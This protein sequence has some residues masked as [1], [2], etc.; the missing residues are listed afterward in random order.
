MNKLLVLAG[1]TA[2]G[3]SD[4][5]LGLAERYQGEII[6][7]DS[8]Q[9]YSGL[10]FITFPPSEDERKKIPHYLI[11][12]IS[13]KEEF[14]VANYLELAVPIVEEIWE[15]GRLPIVVGGTGLYIKVLLEGIFQLPI[16]SDESL[17]K[18]LFEVF[19]DGSL[20]QE[21]SQVD[22]ESANKIHPKDA[23]R[24][25]RAMEVYFLTGKPL[26][27]WKK[28]R[29]G[30]I[31]QRAEKLCFVVLF[32]EREELKKRIWNRLM[33]LGE[34]EVEKAYGLWQKG[35]SRTAAKVLGLKELV[36]VAQGKISLGDAK[37]EIAKATYQYARRQMI[38]FRKHA[39]EISQWPNASVVWLDCR[40]R[41]GF[42]NNFVL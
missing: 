42:L 24:I 1:Q 21:L 36:A 2:T 22:P 40:D 12:V 32:C 25:I 5:A 38:W 39:R 4:L 26:S 18:K 14:N 17:R 15:R 6:S 7:A 37:K 35:M 10:G 19:K 13:P 3:K 34:K 27:Y 23:R 41:E 30:G 8:M 16:A 33:R 20:Y 28:Q 9:I 31:G 29:R 11:E